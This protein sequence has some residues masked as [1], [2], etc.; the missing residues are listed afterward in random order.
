MKIPRDAWIPLVA[1]LAALSSAAWAQS[2]PTFADI[3]QPYVDQGRF[4]GAVGVIVSK[5][6]VVAFPVV[7]FADIETKKP[8][9]RDTVF[10]L[11]STS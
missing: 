2:P 5:N 4:A 7:G 3:V 1:G 11:A 10:W 6:E 8:M 9:K